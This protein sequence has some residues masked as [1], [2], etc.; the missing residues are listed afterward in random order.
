MKVK[1]PCRMKI[2]QAG[3]LLTG[4]I[5]PSDDNR[6]IFNQAVTLKDPANK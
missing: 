3:S 1:F 4:E 2:E 6:Y 5:P